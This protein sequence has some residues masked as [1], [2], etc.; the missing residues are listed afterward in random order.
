MDAIPQPGSVTL[1]IVIDAVSNPERPLATL[2][3][4]DFSLERLLAMNIIVGQGHGL[5]DLHR[6]NNT[7]GKIDIGT[8][9]E[10][11]SFRPHTDYPVAGLGCPANR[12]LTNSER[13]SSPIGV[14]RGAIVIAEDIGIKAG[15][16]NRFRLKKGNVQK[17]W[18]FCSRRCSS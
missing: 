15:H 6:V 13:A 16:G 14:W 18:H 2:P 12:R 17:K 10:T 4:R 5:S 8:V 9:F 1:A 7:T 11:N 3:I